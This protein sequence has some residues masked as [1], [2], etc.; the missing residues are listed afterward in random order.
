MII[1]PLPPDYSR[2]DEPGTFDLPYSLFD[3][4]SVRRVGVNAFALYTVLV[5]YAADNAPQERPL[6]ALARQLQLP[7]WQTRHA[8]HRLAHARLVSLEMCADEIAS[9]TLCSLSQEGGVQ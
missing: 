7:V 6:P 1:H 3:D 5:R 2:S 4:G 8:L 9:V